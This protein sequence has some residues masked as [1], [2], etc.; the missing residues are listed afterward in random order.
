M[1]D[2]PHGAA[3]AFTLAALR[4]DLAGGITAAILTIPV[5]MGYGLLALHVLGD[6]YVSYGILAGLLS[7]I[8]VPLTC[9]L[10]GTR[11]AMMYAPRSVVTFLIA[12]VVLEE[13]V[14]GP[15]AVA[16]LGDIRWT[17]T[18]VFFVIVAAGLFQAL[19]GLLRLGGLIRYIPS[20]VMAGFQNA[21]ALLIFLSQLD[22]M[23]GFPRHIPFTRIAAN[24]S[25][26]QPLT[27][28]VGLLTCLVIWFGPRLSKQIPP[29]IAGLLVGTAAYWSLS[30]LGYGA[31]LGRVVGPMP[32]TVPTPA[33]LAGFGSLLLGTRE[34][35]AVIPALLIGA[36][37]LAIVGSLD[38]LLCLKMVE[39]V[40]RQKSNSSAELRR[41]GLGNMVAACF[42]GI[43][44]GVNLGANLA[45]YRAGGRSWVS[46]VVSAGLILLAVLFLGPVIA[47]LPRVVIA[48]TLVIVSIQ[49]VDRWSVQLFRKAVAGKLVH[50][51]VMTLDLLVVALVATVTIA[52]DLVTGVVIGVAVAIVFFLV[53]MSKSVVRRTYRGDAVR[54]RRARDPRLMELLAAEG[55]RIVVLE[56]EG[57]IFFGTAEDL[58]N[59]VEA[60][61]RDGAVYVVFDLKRVNEL[62]S[63]GARIILQI[64]E[65]L[66]R[67][68]KRLLVSHLQDNPLLAN[69]LTDMGVTAAL[70][71]E[72]VFADSDGALEW[73]EDQVILGHG[74]DADL[75][76]EV[77]VDRLTVLAGLTEA[78]CALVK[79]MLLRRTYR[80]GEIVIV[81]GSG[82]RDLFLMSRGTASVKV[83]VPGQGRQRRLASFSAGSVFGEIALLD[84]QPRSATVT[85]DE[86]MVCY[87]LTEDAFRT[88][89]REHQSVAITILRNLGREL[90]QRLRRATAMISQLE[91]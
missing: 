43:A 26:V 23:L 50:W 58:A 48:A 19:F 32:S 36:F 55:R 20:P 11:V 28:A 2:A 71:R 74:A 73:A 77:G 16:P 51:K 62:D 46:S 70:G 85:A 18:L 82:E 72:A 4:G 39:G 52:F 13:V 67:E 1:S 75:K 78:E 47:Y 68:G 34:I 89:V 10:L 53:R 80:K 8:F 84:E 27:L 90:S 42:G 15:A 17:L 31:G 76:D 12:S 38:A 30:A 83:G 40:T 66:K 54:S 64:H 45:N 25:L 86:D 33:Y 88:L 37:S 21:V 60:A 35:L 14:R 57:P 65:R 3:R 49:L 24:L 44:S 79:G 29:T 69:V 87:V 41:L 81:E 6:Q 56:L 22:T 59:R 91:G 63:T 7:A 61:A 5:S 9:V